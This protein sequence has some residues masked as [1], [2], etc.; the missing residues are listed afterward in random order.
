MC[1]VAH[2]AQIPPFVCDVCGLS[3]LGV[4]AGHVRDD[5]EGA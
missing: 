3:I 1:V 2:P 5:P 4:S